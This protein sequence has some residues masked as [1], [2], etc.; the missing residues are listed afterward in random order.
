MEKNTE[1]GVNSQNTSEDI[2]FADE[3]SIENIEPDN[4]ATN[5][6]NT[7]KSADKNTS[8]EDQTSSKGTPTYTDRERQL[9]ERAKK[10][11]VKVKRLEHLESQVEQTKANK[12]LGAPADIAKVVHALKD[13]STEEVDLIFRQA[14]SLGVSPLE[15]V[16]DE[17]VGLLIQAKREKV[18]R[19][20]KTPE[21][22]NRQS[23][24]GKT[25]EDWTNDDISGSSLEEVGKY[26]DWLKQRSRG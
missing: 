14:K 23:I 25:Y 9:Y 3:E 19:E 11:E 7:G 15:A 21:P 20:N 2:E 12:D 4:E 17:D 10:A 1:F 13:Y 22:T 24:Q 5:V 16:K 26:Y 18:A 6:G 8:T